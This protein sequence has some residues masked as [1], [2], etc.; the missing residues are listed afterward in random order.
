MCPKV[1]VCIYYYFIFFALSRYGM[2]EAASCERALSSA[3]RS[4]RSTLSFSF[5]FIPFDAWNMECVAQMLAVS[6]W[7]GIVVVHVHMHLNWIA[8]YG[9]ELARCNSVCA[10]F[11]HAFFTQSKTII[12]YIQLS[13]R[14]SLIYIYIYLEPEREQRTRNYTKYFIAKKSKSNRWATTVAATRTAEAP[15]TRRR[16]RRWWWWSYF[17]HEWEIQTKTVVMA[18]REGGGKEWKEKC[19]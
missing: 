12:K 17:A 19:K 15:N 6:L 9:N 16:R 18:E 13:R 7:V 5:R 10:C 3:V 8:F 2:I 14:V 1:S 11:F 4:M